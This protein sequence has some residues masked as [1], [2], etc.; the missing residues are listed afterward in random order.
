MKLLC[1]ALD[2]K[3]CK[4]IDSFMAHGHTNA[5]KIASGQCSG[6]FT[7]ETRGSMASRAVPQEAHK[8]K[9]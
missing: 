3:K 1:E 7:I 4:V 9:P 5:C 6:T 2:D 8:M